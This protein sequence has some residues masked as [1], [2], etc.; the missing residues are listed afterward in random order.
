MTECYINS[1]G[2]LYRLVER[3]IYL[4]GGHEH[5]VYYFVNFSRPLKKLEYETILPEGY[6]IVEDR[7]G[8]P[9]LQKGLKHENNHN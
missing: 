7:Y 9:R 2:I 3:K 5:T 6:E 1:K 8:Y 4:R